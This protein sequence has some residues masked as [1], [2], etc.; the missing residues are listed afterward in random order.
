MS[1]CGYWHYKHPWTLEPQ[2]IIY[3]IL[4][5]LSVAQ[6]LCQRQTGLQSQGQRAGH[7][8]I[9]DLPYEETNKWYGL[10]MSKNDIEKCSKWLYFIITVAKCFSHTLAPCPGCYRWEN[11][12]RMTYYQ[13]QAEAAW[14]F[15]TFINKI[16]SPLCNL[17]WFNDFC[18]PK[19]LFGL[20]YLELKSPIWQ[21]CCAPQ[22]WVLLLMNEEQVQFLFHSWVISRVP[23]LLRLREDE[24]K[25][26]VSM[27]FK[28]HSNTNTPAEET[29]AY[30]NPT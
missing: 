6:L 18:C 10:K 19:Q 17:V 25:K 2:V 29:E 9:H 13:T 15:Q 26:Y 11:W 16:I 3:M 8:D 12:K 21:N 7:A 28:S 24:D 27:N 4:L 22:S 1:S 30:P 14:A 20:N 5:S 23:L